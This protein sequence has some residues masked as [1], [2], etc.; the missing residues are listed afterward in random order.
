M[1]VN[2]S[3]TPFKSTYRFYY[4]G[5]SSTKIEKFQD[6]KFFCRVYDIE[7][8]S[9]T[10]NYYDRKKHPE[11]KDAS[12][13]TQISV[14]DSMDSEVERYCTVMGIEFDKIDK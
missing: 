10:E 7:H 3:N 4:G 13:V 11:F 1:R 2:F 9:L 8:K 14:D 5:K 12:I 6:M